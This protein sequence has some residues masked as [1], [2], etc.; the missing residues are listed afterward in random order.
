[1]QGGMIIRSFKDPNLATLK[2]PD[3]LG[4]TL[5]TAFYLKWLTG[6]ILCTYVGVKRSMGGYGKLYTV[7]E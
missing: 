1:M 3:V 4:Q 7:N 6:L 5:N 2:R